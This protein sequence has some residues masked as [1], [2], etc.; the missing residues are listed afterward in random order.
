MYYTF[1]GY[2]VTTGIFQEGEKKGTAWQ[3]IKLFVG[4]SYHKEEEPKSTTILKADK[5]LLEFIQ[6]LE[7]GCKLSLSFDENGKVIGI[8]YIN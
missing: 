2:L 3:S 8:T 1:G 5:K 4:K 6:N 7:H